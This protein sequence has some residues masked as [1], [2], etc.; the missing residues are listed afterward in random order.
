MNTLKLQNVSSLLN[1]PLQ[2]SVNSD[3][4]QQLN[5]VGILVPDGIL[6][7]VGI[8]VPHGILNTVCILVP[9]GKVATVYVP[10]TRLPATYEAP[11]LRRPEY[12]VPRE[13]KRGFLHGPEHVCTG[14]EHEASPGVWGQSW[15]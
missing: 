1:F 10:V 12:G 7:T 9:H 3:P 5:T 4:I 8:P 14:V 6:N 11:I 15:L 13:C 2:E